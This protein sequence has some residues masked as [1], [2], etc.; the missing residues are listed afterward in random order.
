MR[1]QCKEAENT[2]EN[3]MEMLGVKHTFVKIKLSKW[4]PK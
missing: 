3:Q 1:S 2:K 4:T